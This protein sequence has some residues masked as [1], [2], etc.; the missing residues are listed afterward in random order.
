MPAS[1]P[2]LVLSQACF[3]SISC[4]SYYG[5]V[6]PVVHYPATG[7]EPI[8][9]VPKY[10]HSSCMLPKGRPGVPPC[11]KRSVSLDFGDVSRCCCCLAA[12]ATNKS[13]AVSGLRMLLC[14]VAVPVLT[15]ATWHALP[16][17]AGP[18]VPSC[19][20][21]DSASCAREG[22]CRLHTVEDS[23]NGS[24]DV[25]DDESKH[26]A[27]ACRRGSELCARKSMMS[28]A[29]PLLSECTSYS[30]MWRLP[31]QCIT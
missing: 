2:T 9:N 3:R 12:H 20:A 8:T 18:C 22:H 28:S 29:S 31:A 24:A 11:E 30:M 19:Y 4:R 27:A 6:W 21:T 17:S 1:W 16:A 15:T 23:K 10:M 25:D 13:G 7:P 5:H 14:I 26:G